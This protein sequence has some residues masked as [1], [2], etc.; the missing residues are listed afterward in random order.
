M[1]VN[2]DL[3][4]LLD[5]LFGIGP[6]ADARKANQDYKSLLLGLNRLEP[7]YSPSPFE[8]AGPWSAGQHAPEGLDPK[9]DFLAKKLRH[10]DFLGANNPVTAHEYLAGALDPVGVRQRGTDDAFKAAQT[11]HMLAGGAGG[12][13][14]QFGL[15]WFLDQ[16][17]DIQE[18]AILW[19]HG[20]VRR[21]T[22]E[23]LLELR[24]QAVLAGDEN[25][26]NRIDG[27]IARLDKMT[28]AAGAPVVRD[29]GTGEAEYV[30]PPS[31]MIEG[32]GAV[33]SAKA[34]G[35]DVGGQ[36]AELPTLEVNFD[37]HLSS[38]DRLLEHPGFTSGVAMGAL[39]P[40]RWVPGTQENDFRLALENM[41]GQL[42]T[43]AY[44]TLKGGGHITEF[45]AQSVAKGLA[46]LDASLSKSEFQKN[47]GNLRKL[48]TE[49]RGSIR[50]RARSGGA[51]SDTPTQ[52]RRVF[53][54]ATGEFN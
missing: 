44:N 8:T 4:P 6:H 9:Q 24:Q 11:Q 17:S 20:P 33:E 32:A 3:A 54:P 2:I 40:L 52:K 46:N 15:G 37:H 47:A 51:P 12:G 18:N 39:N 53:D 5:S 19:K 35:Q 48:L 49:L 30:V 23:R 13:D 42:Y 27:E 31:E 45:E 21:G 36:G 28:G 50:T 10:A 14:D 41:K 43:L 25:E 16:P 38:I 34:L 22:F 29:R 1:A 26:V 7:D